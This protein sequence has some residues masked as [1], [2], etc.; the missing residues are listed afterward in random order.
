MANLRVT[1]FR[2][3]ST[4]GNNPNNYPKTWGGSGAAHVLII[5]TSVTWDD[6]YGWWAVSFPITGF[7]GFFVS[8]GATEPLPIKLLSFT[9]S[10]SGQANNTAWQTAFESKGSSFI[11]ERSSNGSAFNAISTSIESKGRNS[12]YSFMDN[13]PLSPVSYYRL[14][15]TEVGGAVTYSNIVAVRRSS[16]DGGSITISPVPASNAITVTNT[17]QSLIGNEAIIFDMQGRKVYQFTIGTVSTVDVQT[18]PSG[19]YSLRLP[20]GAVVKIVKQ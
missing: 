10:A 20:G 1:Q 8:T 2:G 7:S 19:I 5:P 13:T 15:A 14:K 18:W 6:Y 16:N 3:I 9:A 11:V 4:G 12:T 17:D